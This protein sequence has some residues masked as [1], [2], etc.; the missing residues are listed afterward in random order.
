MQHWIRVSLLCALATVACPLNA[1]P[2]KPNIVFYFIDDLGWTDVSFMGSKFYETPHVDRLAKEWMVF[3][4]AYACA[5]NCAPSRACLMSGLYGPRHGV[6]TVANS[7]RGQSKYRKLVPIKNTRELAGRFETIAEVLQK[8]GYVTA[9]MGK[10]HLGKDP[11]T[12]GFDVNIA[13]REWGSPSGGGYHSPYKYPN[14]VNPK[15]GEYLTDRLASEAC[16]FIETNK[17]KP[18]FLYLTHYTVHTPIQA[19]ADL[20]AKYEKKK[21]ATGHKNAKYAA[22]IESMNDSVGA[23]QATLKRLKLDG[24]TIVIFFSDN[25]GHGA[26]TSNA[27][28]RGS[29]GMLYEGGI[30]EPLIIKW[31]GVTEAG[32]T[33]REPVIGVDFYPT[34]M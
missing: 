8:A 13:G 33:C 27:P 10:W 31:P 3:M 30:R 24:N 34:L 14:L 17:D 6:Y 5:P 18:F 19:K 11:T 29:K 21:T 15:K 26:V 25:G 23:V 28:L 2:A 12:Q 32:S 4:D 20:T 1:A 22:M 7:D 16:K 9:T